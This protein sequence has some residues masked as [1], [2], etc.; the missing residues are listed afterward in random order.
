[1]LK[2]RSST[3]N[4]NATRAWGV[5]MLCVLVIGLI[6]MTEEAKLAQMK[7]EV[8][9]TNNKRAN[10]EGAYVEKYRKLQQEVQELGDEVKLKDVA[11]K[12]KIL[13]EKAEA[14]RLSNDLNQKLTQDENSRSEHAAL[15]ELE[16]T[17]KMEH[18]ELKVKHETL[19][20]AYDTLKEEHET[21][22]ARYKDLK[23][24]SVATQSALTAALQK[25]TDEIKGSE[26]DKSV[27][28]E[29][30]AKDKP[31][32]TEGEVHIQEEQNHAIATKNQ[33]EN[34]NERENQKEMEKGGE[35][36]T[37][38]VKRSKQT[39]ILSQDEA[40]D[41]GSSSENIVTEDKV[42]KKL[43]EKGTDENSQ[44]SETHN[45]QNQEGEQD[46]KVRAGGGAAE[47]D[48]GEVSDKGE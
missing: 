34:E 30:D 41:S 33:H 36:D 31:M 1:M 32:K 12:E 10:S 42:S 26:R 5:V 45:N 38:S 4:A 22:Q 46:G 13:T 48:D 44:N 9:E 28:K 35:A 23:K 21:L 29:D 40:R 24:D 17:L 20:D 19:K 3:M 25:C 15:K 18:E 16:H 7:E 27:G 47:S 8:A 2:P 37:D 43:A 14:E 6:Y 39:S 11:C